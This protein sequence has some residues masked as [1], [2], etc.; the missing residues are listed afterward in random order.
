MPTFQPYEPEQAELLPAHVR[1]VL[2]ANHL[3]FLIS[4]VVER[5]ELREFIAVYSDEGGQRPYHPALM[6]KVWLYG[7]AV[8]VKTT[9]KLEQRVKEDLAFRYLAGGAAPDHKTLS[10]FQ[11]RHA[12]AIRAYF[13]EVLRWLQQAGLARVGT[14]AIDSTRIKASA[15]RD[16]VVKE[17]E[18]RRQL[19]DK[20]RQWQESLDEDPDR[21]PGT[22]LEPETLQR[23]RQQL[24]KLQRQGESCLSLTDEDARF[25]RDHGRFTLGYTGELAVSEDHFIVAARVTQSKSDNAALLPLVAEVQRQCRQKPQRVLADSGF[26]SQQ[27]LAA[28]ERHGIDGYVPDS[29]LAAEL[30]TGR[31]SR[32]DLRFGAVTHRMRQKLRS[33]AGRAWYRRRKA[34]VELVFGVLKQQRGMR[35]FERRGLA[36][37]KTEWLLAAIAFNLTRWYALSHA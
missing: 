15:S 27:N 24:A 19:Q 25:V 20:V 4:E 5:S 26:F 8:G 13:G 22:L 11:R 17:R 2:G 9:R 6:L 21:T 14:V 31:A 7:F 33:P 30:N 34:L 1:D 3:C 23:V 32:G 18:L 10:E 28:L 12:A 37:V 16:R 29:N 36:A 35:Q